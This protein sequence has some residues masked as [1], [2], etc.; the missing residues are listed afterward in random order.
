MDFLANVKKQEEKNDM[1]IKKEFMPTTKSS[2][3]RLTEG[4]KSFWNSTGA[5]PEIRQNNVF[6]LLNAA[7][8]AGSIYLFGQYGSTIAL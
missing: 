6:L 8:F 7:L 3:Y 1:E 2:Y 5:T 4:L